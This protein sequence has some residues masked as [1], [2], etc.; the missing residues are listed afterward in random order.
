MHTGP[1]QSCGGCQPA[2]AFLAAEIR[3]ET[4]RGRRQEG[5]ELGVLKIGNGFAPTSTNSF[6]G[7]TTTGLRFMAPELKP[8]VSG[9]IRF[10]PGGTTPPIT[11]SCDRVSSALRGG[12]LPGRWLS[13]NTADIFIFRFLLLDFMHEIADTGRH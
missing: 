6:L 9:L 1:H 11:S 12:P 4:T 8:G 7:A 5:Q 3:R 13:S 10:S 2:R